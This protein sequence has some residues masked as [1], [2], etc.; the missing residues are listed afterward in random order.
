[1]PGAT[2][3][4]KFTGKVLKRPIQEQSGQDAVLTRA[5]QKRMRKER[6]LAK[7][8]GETIEKAKGVWE[9]ARIKSCPKDK[10]DVYIE[11]LFDALAPKIKDISTRIDGCRMIQTLVKYGTREQ[12]LYIGEQLLG[13]Y[14]DMSKSKFGKFVVIKLLQYQP[15]MRIRIIAE[16]SGSV[17]KLLRHRDAAIVVEM[18]YSE[19]ANAEQRMHL[20][21]EFYGAEFVLFK[22]QHAK[23]LRE[24]LELHPG[25]KESISQSLE[26]NLIPIF[27]KPLDHLQTCTIVHRAFYDFTQVANRAA[28]LRMA[29]IAKD[30]F[31]NMVHTTEGGRAVRACILHSGAK[32]RKLLLRCFKGFVEKMAIEP[33]SYIVLLTIFSCVDDTVLVN[34]LVISE[35]VK[36]LQESPL[37]LLQKYGSRVLLY[38]LANRSRRY[39]SNDCINELVRDDEIVKETSKKN[40][41]AR[42]DELVKYAIQPVID[43]LARYADLCVRNRYGAEVMFEALR[44]GVEADREALYSSVADIACLTKIDDPTVGSKETLQ[45]LEALLPN[46][47]C[48]LNAI[49]KS[50]EDTTADSPKGEACETFHPVKSMSKVSDAAAKAAVVEHFDLKTLIMASKVSTRLLKSAIKENLDFARKVASQLSVNGS[51][52]KWI[53]HIEAEPETAV[54]AGLVIISLVETGD[55]EV[56]ALIKPLLAEKKAVLEGIHHKNK[57]K[58]Y[59]K[60]LSGLA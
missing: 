54:G 56:L 8:H 6:K 10:R 15:K 43:G 55:E 45:A 7:P 24:L 2:V 60:V 19:Y 4:K 32:E 44:A 31:I 3:E 20:V 36:S 25:K 59:L 41:S 27:S 5:D 1:M 46:K 34:K 14:V 29:D 22:D 49:D 40:A 35:L 23:N 50:S 58:M 17:T 30:Q 52:F 11:K 37:L 12:T 42:H 51:L 9:K 47:I 39:I 48:T 57:D 16:F 21:R 38:L 18:L 33:C 28:I 26:S 13:S 53:E